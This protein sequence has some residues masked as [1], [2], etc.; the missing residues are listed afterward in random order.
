MSSPFTDRE[1]QF[2]E[3]L[4]DGITAAKS[5]QHKLAESLLNRAIYLNNN[6]AR[7]YIW[8]SSITNN[9]KEQIEY[10]E[11]A[12]AIDPT[13]AAARGWRCSQANRPP[14]WPKGRG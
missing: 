6:D 3:Y 12:V 8:L 10:L 2:E 9:P 11:R 7:P 14:T 13:N 5:G 1:R 4:R